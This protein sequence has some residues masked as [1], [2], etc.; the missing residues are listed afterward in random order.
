M[1]IIIVIC[2]EHGIFYSPNNF[3]FEILELCSKEELDLKEQEYIKSYDTM[4]NGYNMD[5]GGTDGRIISDETREKIRKKMRDVSGENNPMYG[6]KHSQSTKD[7]I[8]KAHKGKK[9][10]EEHIQRL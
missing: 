3:S 4:I 7:K 8:S 6:R 2:K 5:S 10:S 9:L 1:N